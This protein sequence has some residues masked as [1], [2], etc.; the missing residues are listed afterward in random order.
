MSGLRAGTRVP[1]PPRRPRPLQRPRRHDPQC[2][3]HR[4]GI[5]S[6][7]PNRDDPNRSNTYEYTELTAR[8]GLISRKPRLA[9][10]A[11]SIF[12][13]NHQAHENLTGTVFAL[14]PETGMG[15]ITRL[16]GM[17]AEVVAGVAD[18]VLARSGGLTS[19]KELHRSLRT[20]HDDGLRDTI[21]KLPISQSAIE[22]LQGVIVPGDDSILGQWQLGRKQGFVNALNAVQVLMIDGAQSL[23]F[24]ASA[25]A[26]ISYAIDG[27]EVCPCSCL[28]IYE[29]PEGWAGMFTYET[30]GEDRASPLGVLG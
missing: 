23:A 27:V 1:K 7:H 28:L 6:R 25:V 10:D 26:W 3:S 15:V 22:S 5:E 19:I 16:P 11:R 17:R 24:V 29:G 30:E 9:T 2:L 4:I 8:Y 13:V 20:L 21:A 12:F 14:A 18:G